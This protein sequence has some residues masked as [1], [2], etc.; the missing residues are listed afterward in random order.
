MSECI[1]YKVTYY[2]YLLSLV[3]LITTAFGK[4]I[5]CLA[6]IGDELYI[7]ALRKGV[8]YFS[9]YGISYVAA[10]SHHCT[11]HLKEIILRGIY[12][13]VS[14]VQSCTCQSI[15]LLNM[16][17]NTFTSTNLQ[18]NNFYYSLL[19]F[20]LYYVYAAVSE[21]CKFRS[22]SICQFLVLSEF[23]QQLQ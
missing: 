10:G 11:L 16:L 19:Y 6:K 4:A 20:T 2:L 23:L 14:I 8:R 7:E 15:M 3:Y 12:Y 22:L 17:S 5:Q 18:C 1:V 21:D 9:M 13:T